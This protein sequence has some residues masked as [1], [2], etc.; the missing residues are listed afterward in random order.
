LFDSGCHPW[1]AITMH[2]LASAQPNLANSAAWIVTAPFFF[3]FFFSQDLITKA[4]NRIR[5]MHKQDA[6]QSKL[7]LAGNGKW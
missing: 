2:L 3:F 7:N 6:T 4:W 5:A 1:K